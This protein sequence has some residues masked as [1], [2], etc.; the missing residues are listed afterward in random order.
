MALRRVLKNQFN[1]IHK[2]QAQAVRGGHGWDRPDV[3]LSFNP[4]YVHKREL[5]IFDTNMWMYDQ[6]YPEYVISYNEIHLVDQWKGLK[7]SFSQSAYWWAMMAMVFGFYFI[8]T[9]PRQLGIDTN[10]LKGFLGEYYGQYKKRS[11]I[12]SNFL[13]LDVTGENSIIQPNYDRKN[14]IRDVID[15]LNADAGKR[16]LI[17]LEAKNFI[18]RVEKECEQRILKKGGA[19]QSHH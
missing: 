17:N 1:L 2:G 8:N 5:S 4:L 18:E 9:T 6:V 12:R 3:P 7:E 15:S 14:G 19:T 16:K 11:G 10:D 13:G